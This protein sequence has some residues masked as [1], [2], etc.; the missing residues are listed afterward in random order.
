MKTKIRGG[1]RYKYCK[2]H[3]IWWNTDESFKCPLCK[4]GEP[5]KKE[6]KVIHRK[7]S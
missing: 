4:W 3:R 6:Q 1:I 7:R 2:L 5:A